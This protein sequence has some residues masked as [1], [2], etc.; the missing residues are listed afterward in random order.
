MANESYEEFASNLQKEYETDQN[1][2]FGVIE[3]HS[4]ANIAVKKKDGKFEY[5]GQVASEQ[6]HKY[7]ENAG[8]IDDKGKVQDKL[9][10]D[11]KGGT[12]DLPQE[13]EKS[14]NAIL[15]VARK[16]SGN[17]N[18]KPAED[19][20]KIE[21]NKAVY[22]S[23]DF[24]E[25][26]ERIKYKTTYE[27]SFS[28]EKLIE[29]CIK[30]MVQELDVSVAKL[31]YTK[32]KTTVSIGGVETTETDRS[33][34]LASDIKENLPDVITFLQNETNL[35]RK[36]IATI[37]VDSGTLNLFKKN[38]QKYME[39]TLKTISSKMRLMIVDG[40][41]YT[42]IGDDEYYAQELFENNE[43][44]GYLSRNMIESQ[45][46]PYAYVVFDSQNEESFA[47]SF[48]N[49]SSIKMYAK[50]PPWFK[51]ST[52]LGTYNPDWAVLIEKDGTQKLYFVLETKA[53][54]MTEALRPTESAKIACG[55]KHFEA[56]GNDVVFEEIDMF[57]KFIE[58]VV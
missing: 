28:T 26:W 54:T 19:K 25:L 17:L 23:D 6:I 15:A 21:L 49:N 52:P 27:V 35:T 40:I 58:E 20:K 10:A 13:F 3:S 18:I 1:I 48:E 50:L 51:I 46:T 43:L 33:T 2:R 34:V 37:L 53:N 38:P 22:L 31:V 24:K 32:A 16:A 41:K 12:V 9:R 11:I 36:T 8:Y 30:E 44:F 55:Y 14:K 39:E 45:K 56:L 5:L 57:S 42:K 4:F 47:Q 29:E 7:F